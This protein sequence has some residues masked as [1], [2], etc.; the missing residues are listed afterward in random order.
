MNYL[1]QLKLIA[2]QLDCEGFIKQANRIDKYLSK[3]GQAA[4]PADPLALPPL[5]ENSPSPASSPSIEP[6]DKVDTVEYLARTTLMILKKLQDFFDNYGSVLYYLGEENIRMIDSA[7]DQ[8]TNMYEI[9]MKQ[10][11]KTYDERAVVNFEAHLKRLKL[12]VD[13]SSKMRITP[14]KVKVD[15]F[16][17]FDELVQI[18]NRIERHYDDGLSDLQPVLR[19]IRAVINSFANVIQQTS[20]QIANSDLIDYR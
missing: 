4:P 8:L 17:F 9:A 1:E 10:H 15:K 7:L 14:I 20:E 19:K 11:E 16:L 5:D 3:I 6:T 13:R 18:M 12:E 2:D